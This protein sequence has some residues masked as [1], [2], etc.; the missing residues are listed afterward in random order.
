MIMLANK[1]IEKVF[2][3]HVVTNLHQICLCNTLT[4]IGSPRV[5]QGKDHHLEVFDPRI[6]T[7]IMNTIPY[8][9]MLTLKVQARL[10]IYMQTDKT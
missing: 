4:L 10:K 5:L 8:N 2:A 9:D 6:S 3:F 1:P 7:P